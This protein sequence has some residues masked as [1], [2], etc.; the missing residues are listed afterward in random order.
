MGTMIMLAR[1]YGLA[2]FG[3]VTAMQIANAEPSADDENF[4]W[5][6]HLVEWQQEIKDPRVFLH[7]LKIDLYPDEVYTFTP[8][9][10]VYAF[11]RGAT[12]LDF[13]Y[14]IHT[15]LGNHCVGARINGKLVPLRTPL[16]NGD[17]VEVFTSPGQTPS[18]EW[19]SIVGTSRA[20]HKIRHW[21]NTEQKVRSIELGRRLFEK[22][23]KKYR[24]SIKK[25]MRDGAL[26]S[27]VEEHGHSRTDDLF[28]DVGFGKISAKTI[29]QRLIPDD[30]R[31]KRGPSAPGLFQQAVRKLLPLG[32]GS[33]IRVRGFDDLL[34]YLARCCSPL[35]GEEIVGYITRGKGVAVHSANCPNVKNLLFSPDR[36]IEVEWGEG[37]E[38]HFQVDLEVIVTDQTGVLAKVI[39]SIANLKTN[40]R[41][42]EAKVAEGRGI[43]DLSVEIADRRHLDR[44]VK[45]ISGIDGV[46]RVERRY[47]VWDASA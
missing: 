20:R 30:Q 41:N 12:P 18:Q 35:P 2:A 44:L 1:A 10:D 7:S 6:R 15:D 26:A 21:L 22:E 8:R 28:A 38:T 27:L 33:V 13:A 47:R 17:I 11:P 23:A 34:T 19:L 36:E 46:T 40:I 4:L 14:R 45:A 9:G 16:N 42:M 31:E 32:S 25:L 37:K 39:S 29:V 5:L 3:S 43:I 24:L